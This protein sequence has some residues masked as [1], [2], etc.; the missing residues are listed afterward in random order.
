[1]NIQ[2]YVSTQAV[3][4]K[5]NQIIPIWDDRIVFEKTEMY[6]NQIKLKGDSFN[7]YFSVIECIYDLKTKQ[8][9]IGI[10]LNQYPDLEKLQYKTGELVLYEKTPRCL[11]EALI[12]DIIFEE[13]DLRIKRG[14][15]LNNWDL[16]SF[17]GVERSKDV[18]YAIKSWKPVY[19]LDNGLK[20]EYDHQLYRKVVKD[21]NKAKK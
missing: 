8:I 11:D 9:E 10:E 18:L 19:L 21:I 1:M 5:D 2:R 13:Y 12:Q 16:K 3:K 14:H 20:I 15:K 17:E 7:E 4:T 6:G